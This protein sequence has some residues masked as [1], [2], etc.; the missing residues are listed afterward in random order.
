MAGDDDTAAAS[1]LLLIDEVF[2]AETSFL[3]G[4][5]KGVGIL[6]GAN[7]ADVDN[8]IRRENVLLAGRKSECTIEAEEPGR[9]N[10]PGRPAQYSEL[11]RRR[12]A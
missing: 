1:G 10:S 2:S 4:R 3:T 12:S 9:E 8:G 11:L 5:A 6:V 7:A